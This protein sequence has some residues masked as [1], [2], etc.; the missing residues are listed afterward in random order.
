MSFG[1]AK[2]SAVGKEDEINICHISSSE[3][4]FKLK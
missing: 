1:S 2:A 4:T 3:S